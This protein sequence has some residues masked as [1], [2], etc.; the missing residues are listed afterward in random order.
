MLVLSVLVTLLAEA[1]KIYMYIKFLA[2]ANDRTTLD[3]RKRSKMST[4]IFV[5]K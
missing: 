2:N 3:S 4:Q 1:H 5:L